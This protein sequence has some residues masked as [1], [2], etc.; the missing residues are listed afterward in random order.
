MTAGR[1]RC[2][3]AARSALAAVVAVLVAGVP[4]IASE[5]PACDRSGS[6]VARE[7]NPHCPDEEAPP[8][9]R[10][11]DGRIDDWT[12]ASTLLG[13]TTQVSR[14]EVV[15]Q[16]HLFDDL[17]GDTGQRSVQHG[18][19]QAPKGDFRYPADDARY[20]NNAADLLELRL[21]ADADDLWILARMSTLKVSDATVVALAFDLDPGAG[22]GGGAWPHDAGLATPGADVV[23][24]LW[25]TGGSVTSPLG[26]EPAPLAGVAV[27]TDDEHNA[28]EARVPLAALGGATAMRVWA[29]SG[30][31]DLASQAWMAVPSG[32]PTQTS[33]GGGSPDVEARAFNI[34]FRDGETGSYLEEAQAAAL[35]A[36]DIAGFHVDVDITA[37]QAGASSPYEIEPGRFYAAIVDQG[38]SIPPEH[39]GVSYVGTPGRFGGAA[40]ALS[41]TFNFY[42]R[43]QPYGLYLPSTYDGT[44]P[45]PAALVL[46]GLGGSHASYNR[47]PGFLADMGEGDGSDDQSPLVLITPLAR[48]SSFYADWGE[49]DTLAVLAD[50]Q[51]RFPIDD[52]RLYL[53]GYS[54]GGYGVYRLASLY[55]DRFAAAAVWAGYSGEFTGAY[56]TDA[57]AL[58]GDPTGQHDTVTGITRPILTGIGVGGGRAGKANIGDPV[59]TLQ[60]LRGVPLLASSG[61]NDEIVPTSGQYAAPRRL[62]ELGY[63]SRFDL[64]P[65]YE[66]F[67]FGILDDWKRTRAWLGN[68]ARES[69]ARVVTYAFSDGWTAPGLAAELGLVHDGAHWLRGLSM[70]EPTED[71]LT[72]ASATATSWGIAAPAV[73]AEQSTS[74]VEQPT[75]H[76][77]QLVSW[78]EG[79]SLPVDNRLELDLAGVGT[80]SVDLGAALLSVCG[81]VVE[82]RSDGPA[83]IRLVGAVPNG[84]TGSGLP[85][86]S[87]ARTS[88]TETVVALA[89]AV[90]GEVVIACP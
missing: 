4:A 41:Q 16:D 39:E 59:D 83:T 6:P 61:T 33:P 55:P 74:V 10:V 47:G 35:A 19:V 22:T 38:F 13:G 79:D 66:H 58:I 73:T 36:G 29:A 46:H 54:M 67:A 72:L 64:Y 28:I 85:G 1:P 82:L 7:R 62:A 8:T 75:P 5:I 51:V 42:G 56:L 21:A 3:L 23:V 78:R 18:T 53:T 37:L 32:A 34:A 69:T 20:G 80:A 26:G 14:G 89:D 70:R 9:A 81:L 76:T 49:A 52:Q 2:T 68:R 15:Y 71:G 17:G 44:T 90:D 45:L 48:G 88:A 57:R 30:L 77:E 50:A 63:R 12:G 24:T 11:L 86:V 60:N 43:L 27:D 65:G 25:G 40:G 31:W 87:V 84:A